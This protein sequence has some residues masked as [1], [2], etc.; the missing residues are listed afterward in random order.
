[1]SKSI[2]ILSLA[3]SALADNLAAFLPW[4][5]SKKYLVSRS[6][7]VSKSQIF[8]RVPASLARRTGERKKVHLV[9]LVRVAS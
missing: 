3:A 2:E 9:T 7:L 5:T 4:S 8:S 1:M 6:S